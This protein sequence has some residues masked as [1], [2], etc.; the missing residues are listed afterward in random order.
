M[1]VVLPGCVWLAVLNAA[2]LDR[3]LV[4]QEALRHYR[5]LVRMDPSSAPGFEAPAVEY[6]ER[7]LEAEGIAVKVFARHPKRPN[8][9][10]RLQGTGAKKPALIMAHP[11]TVGVQP[12]KWSHAPFSADLKGGFVYGRGSVDD[13][14]NATAALV[15]ML[16]LSGSGRDPCPAV[17]CATSLIEYGSVSVRVAPGEDIP[18]FVAGMK[19][20]AHQPGVDFVLPRIFHRIPAPPSGIATGATDRVV[21]QAK[22]VNCYGI[23]PAVNEE[24]ARLGFATHSDQERLRESEFYRF[25]RFNRAT[26]G[27]IAGRN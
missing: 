24:D 7:T 8:L 12:G 15:T 18:A 22:G 14:D 11:D 16:L 1:R 25:T 19:K 20:V 23:G 9:V 17:P 2:E 21:L 26:V 13:K 3:N 10:A 6:L 5:D 4:N 27:S